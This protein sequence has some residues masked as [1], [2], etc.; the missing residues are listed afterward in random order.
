[1]NRNEMPEKS[2]PQPTDDGLSVLADEITSVALARLIEEVR[3]DDAPVPSHYNRS[4][5]RH[6]R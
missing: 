5:H 2:N 3:N 4:Y 6:N 1:M